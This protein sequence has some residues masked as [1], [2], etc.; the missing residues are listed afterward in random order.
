MVATVKLGTLSSV[1]SLLAATLYQEP[2]AF[3]YNITIY[4]YWPMLMSWGHLIGKFGC[5]CASSF[6]YIL[7]MKHS[8][9]MRLLVI[10]SYKHPIIILLYT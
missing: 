5:V 2:Q 6:I 9:I 10:H 4:A 1:V 3:E 8:Y 7:S